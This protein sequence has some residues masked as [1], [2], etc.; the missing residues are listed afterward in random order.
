[1]IPYR[2]GDASASPLV[3][4]YQQNPLCGRLA[5]SRRGE[6]V[7]TPSEGSGLTQ[8][9]CSPGVEHQRKGTFSD[10]AK[11][12]LLEPVIGCGCTRGRFEVTGHSPPPQ[13]VRCKGKVQFK[14]NPGWSFL[15]SFSA[16]ENIATRKQCGLLGEKTLQAL[17]RQ[18]ETHVRVTGG[19]SFLTMTHVS[20]PDATHQ[21]GPLCGDILT[22][23]P[24][25]ISSPS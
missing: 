1:M 12:V 11:R 8:S 17:S 14:W 23:R 24:P 18:A 20:C 9:R 19:R 15:I 22:A 25:V 2:W 5:G 10:T 16:K 21:A 13:R 3:R 6:L 4:F 7:E